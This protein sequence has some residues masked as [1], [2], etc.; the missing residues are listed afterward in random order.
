MPESLEEWRAQVVGLAHQGALPAALMLLR[1]LLAMPLPEAARVVMEAD[2]G[3]IYL[4]MDRAEDA[5]AA[6]E[7]ALNLDPGHPAAMLNL[8][9]ALQMMGECEA[10]TRFY[11]RM[12]AMEPASPLA[13]FNLGRALAI[14]GGEEEALQHLD[15]ALAANPQDGEAHLNRGYALAR[16]FRLDE[17][18]AAYVRA[19]QYL[20]NPDE[21]SWNLGVLR[22]LRGNYPDGWAGY[23]VRWATRQFAGLDRGFTQPQWAGESFAGRTLL[24]HAEQGFGDTLMFARFLAQAKALG[25]RVVLEAQT[26]LCAMLSTCEGVD[27]CL[28]TGSPLPPFDLQAPL[29]SLGR[30]FCPDPG[31]LDGR[32]YLATPRDSPNAQRIASRMEGGEGL[33]VGIVWAGNPGH[34]TDAQRSLRVQDLA[35]LG[36]APGLRWFSLQKGAEEMPVL[37][38]LTNLGDCLD[39]FSDTAFALERLDLLITVDTSVAHLAGALGRPAW[40]L[41]A[42]YPDWRWMLNREDSPWYRSVKLYRQGEVRAWVPVLERVAQDLQSL[43]GT[44]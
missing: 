14:S 31:G 8:A 25:G 32:P 2:L 1:R 28:Q 36:E 4:M 6:C 20:S 41:L 39:D 34:K 18:E 29:H 10:A 12:L 43:C 37:P 35:V 27:V 42:S 19:G 7:R 13:H 33:R 38:G 3:G 21:A 30:L 16:L 5:R 44:C 11:R 24:V 40:V 22:L 9:N 15:Q 23:E 26:Q 17:A